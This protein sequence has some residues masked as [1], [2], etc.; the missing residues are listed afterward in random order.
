MQQK[1]VSDA[2]NRVVGF[3]DKLLR[4]K[5]P[6][7]DQQFHGLLNAESITMQV[8][9]PGDWPDGRQIEVRVHRGGGRA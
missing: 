8:E 3:A 6:P 4:I 9:A 5:R 1:E 2:A 7:I